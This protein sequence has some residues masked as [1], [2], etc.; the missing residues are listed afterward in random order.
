MDEQSN[1]EAAHAT[2]PD[3]AEAH[4]GPFQGHTQTINRTN[5]LI[6]ASPMTNPQRPVS[7]VLLSQMLFGS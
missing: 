4:F 6:Q 3:A 2:G 5:A 7:K 1:S